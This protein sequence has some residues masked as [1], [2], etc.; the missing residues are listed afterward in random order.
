VEAALAVAE[1]ECGVIP[2]EAAQA[3]T[4]AARLEGLD[5]ARIE[6]GIAETSHPLMA[7]V[8]ELSMAAGEHG[9]WVHWGATTQNITQTGDVLVLREAHRVILRLLAGVLIT[10][11]DLA[12]R[13]AGNRVADVPGL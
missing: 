2:A 3:I 10:A 11:A 12:E 7:L 13:T 4:S 1:A 9:G 8:T 5:V 6:R